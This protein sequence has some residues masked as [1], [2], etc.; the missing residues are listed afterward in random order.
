LRLSHVAKSLRAVEIQ[1][2]VRFDAIKLGADAHGTFFQAAMP[3]IQLKVAFLGDEVVFDSFEQI[4]LI[5]LER[6]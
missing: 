6:C 3:L 1:S 2:Q 4:R 5:P